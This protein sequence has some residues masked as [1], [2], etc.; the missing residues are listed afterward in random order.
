M[1]ATPDPLQF[2]R[3]EMDAAPLKCA[4]C[5]GVISS[6]Y[7]ATGDKIVCGRC[8]NA[9]MTTLAPRL[10][11]ARVF[12]AL[13]VGSIG[14]LLGVAL[15]SLVTLLTGYEI[16]LVAIAVGFVVGGGVRLGSRGRGGWFYQLLAVF[17]TYSAIGASYLVVT[18]SYVANGG[19]DNAQPA[20]VIPVDGAN[21]ENPTTTSAPASQ[22]TSSPATQS[23]SMSDA[24]GQVMH[25]SEALPSLAYAAVILPIIVASE[26]PLVIIIIGFALMQAWQLNRRLNVDLKGPFE[27]GASRR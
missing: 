10:A 21:S 4:A 8:R 2:D 14:A 13:F 18:A 24:D 20:L 12:G 5:K 26:S 9:I 16:A 27:V 3:A 11:A 22:S 25:I 19:I 1:S 17:L 6:Q 23:A 7:Y 15:Y